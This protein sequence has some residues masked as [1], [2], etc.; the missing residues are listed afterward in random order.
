MFEVRD[1]T[2]YREKAFE[3]EPGEAAAI[4]QYF[5]QVGMKI[6][7]NVFTGLD[8]VNP[9]DLHKLTSCTTLTLACSNI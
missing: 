6:G 1:Y 2:R 7:C 3:P 9:A 8:C 4:A 5:Q